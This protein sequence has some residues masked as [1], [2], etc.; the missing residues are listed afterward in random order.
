MPISALGTLPGR[1]DPTVMLGAYPMSL[2][3]PSKPDPGQTD[4]MV[5]AVGQPS[6]RW[7]GE[8]RLLNTSS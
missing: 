5:A 1:Q 6:P 2:A 7:I 3:G 8:G 4:E